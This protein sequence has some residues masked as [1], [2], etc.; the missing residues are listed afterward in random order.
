MVSRW[1]YITLIS[2]AALIAFIVQCARGLR[3][4]A[5]WDRLGERFGRTRLRFPNG[6][7]WIH[8]ASMGEV[9]AASALATSLLVRYPESSLLMTTSTP[10][11]A[12]RVKTLFA[13]RVH[14]AFLPYDTPLAVRGFLHAI[15]PRIAVMM[16]TEIWPTLYRECHRAGVPLLV[17]S[18]RLSARS[19]GRYQRV[20]VYLP[21]LVAD[22]LALPHVAAQTLL[23]AERF[24]LIGVPSDRTE[25]LGNLK[26][27]LDVPDD[28]RVHGE[29]L[30]AEWGLRPVWVAGSTHP[31]EE[32][33]LLDA[34]SK[35]REQ[36]RD[37]LLV[38][39]PRH[40]QRFDAVGRDLEAR[41]VR[42]SRRSQGLAPHPHDEVYLADTMGELLRF[43][44]AAD[45]C[46]VGGT[47]ITLGGH[48]LLE[49]AAI[50]KP[51]LCG[52]HTFN[53]GDLKDQLREAGALI[54][55]TSVNALAREVQKL[56]SDTSLAQRMGGAGRAF[57]ER[58]RG[59][60]ERLL[61]RI[62]ELI[63]R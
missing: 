23:D 10:T 31:I 61:A 60:R 21:R 39:V 15:N 48:N 24:Q 53:T 9:Q 59:T 4:R 51:V 12:E 62:D 17:A 26:F 18:A 44:A 63:L 29:R 22:T 46:Y 6:C 20:R 49:P 54:E 5:Y 19:V 47:L 42:F 35:V 32:A 8:A 28:V 55:V 2:V 33:A 40:P 37:A 27:D 45:V 52:P 25:V 36:L 43:F 41:G 16:E 14:H 13:G 56:V 57:V 58:N 30:R 50:G 34:H 3:D 1:V 7:I 11:G 38:I